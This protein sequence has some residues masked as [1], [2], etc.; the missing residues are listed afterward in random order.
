[1]VTRHRI[2]LA[3][4]HSPCRLVQLS[5]L[6]RSW[7]VPEAFIARVVTKT[8]QL[9]PDAVLLGGDFVTRHADY[10]ASC[11]K[12][13]ARL[14]PPQGVYA[15]LGN[16]DYRSDDWH[17]A[18]AIQEGLLSVGVTLLT[19]RSTKLD[20]GL[21]L[22]GLDD[23]ETGQP[24]PDQAFGRVVSREPL[25]AFTHNPLL[26]DVL[27]G[28]PCITV[29]GHT[30]GGQIYLPGITPL[31]MD[32]RARYLRGWFQKPGW[33]GRMYVSCGLGTIVVPARVN[34]PAEIVL[35]ELIPA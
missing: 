3:G 19:N 16:H 21:R 27:C 28:Y 30:H 14:K 35:L 22:V 32:A 34:A 18:P 8:L 15:V 26:F 29:A 13:L 7:C 31:F 4:L 20:C 1:M 25:L 33:P 23:W 12:Q 24:D 10:I 2:R 11:A 17:G 6:H 5:D 9:Q